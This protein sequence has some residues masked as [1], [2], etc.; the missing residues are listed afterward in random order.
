MAEK[1]VSLKRDKQKSIKKIRYL[2]FGVTYFFLS[3]IGVSMLI[4][5]LWMISTSFKKREDV[6]T[7][8]IKW[9]PTTNY[10]IKDGIERN[11]AIVDE[12]P[13]AYDVKILNKEKA[14]KILEG[15]S[16]TSFGRNLLL[17]RVLK[18]KERGA[19]QIYRVQILR[20]VS[21]ERLHIRLAAIPNKF[22]DVKLLEGDN[23]NPADM[24]YFDIPEDRVGEN[25]LFADVVKLKDEKGN[26][27][28]YKCK[29]ISS[30]AR[31]IKTVINPEGKEIALGTE[32]MVVPT[33]KVLNRLDPQWANFSDAWNAISMG[34]LYINSVV[35]AVAITLGQVITSAFAAYAFSRLSFPGRDKIF[36]GYLA[37]MMIPGAVTMIPIFILLKKMPELLNTLFHTQIWMAEMILPFT[38]ISIG[39]PIGL[40]S[41]FA[42]IAPGLFSAY[43]TFMLRQF[44]M[45]LPVELEEAAKID[46]CSLLGIFFK[47]TL[48]LSKPALATL[49][50]FTFMGSW[51]S[52]MW[53]M[54]VTGSEHMKTIPWGLQTFQSVHSTDYTLL[55]T[56]TMIAL[57][58]VIIVFIIGQRYFV[59]GIRLGAVK[60]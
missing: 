33:S 17:Q 53:P 55:M 20:K 23:V 59:E 29:I 10:V 56:G 44:F 57:L 18:L 36:F 19:L 1:I 15:V 51:Q 50:I 26:L 47:I 4:P 14:G 38:N 3:I 46:G 16:G 43:G 58:P 12:M 54:I 25:L 11:V 45:G 48:P 31:G 6:F 49:A 9:L 32:E 2:K 28:E 52:F 27:K 8:K 34:R 24:S 13:A 41:Y 40:D 42:L 37:T 22:Y 39:K 60:G 21:D 35:V 30:S 7:Q 5:F